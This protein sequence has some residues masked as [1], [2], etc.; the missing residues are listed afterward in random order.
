MKIEK[1]TDQKEWEKITSKS[2]YFNLFSSPI[3]FEGLT[4]P[5]DFI[6]L[7]K[8]VNP[9][10][11][12]V[13]FKKE[14]PKKKFFFQDFNYNQG[15]YFFIE[16]KK[17]QLEAVVFLLKELTKKYDQ[18]RF[19]LNYDFN[20]IRAFQWHNYPNC[21]FKF[22]IVYSSIINFSNYK[23]FD[24]VILK[25]RYSRR[26]EKNL[27]DKSDYKIEISRDYK[28]FCQMYILFNKNILGDFVINTHLKLIENSFKNNFSR[29]S[30]ITKNGE[31][32][33]GTV[34][35]YYNRRAYYAFSVVNKLQENFSLTSPLIIEQLKYFYDS[36]FEYVDM[37]GINSP[38][39]GD[40]KESFG[41][42]TRSFYEVIYE[43]KI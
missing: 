24:D 9:I 20:D 4:C 41:G 18:L 43:K 1:L 16:D 34:F 2:K 23:S 28:T 5:Y 13:V 15:M 11:S 17:K 37:M 7:R 32:L 25:F 26:R 38:G 14:N 10:L 22:N 31:I 36:N 3:F 40:F 6:I 42:E 33:G 19:S 39:R 27:F 35:Y 21:E 12:C 30:F 8:G 29:L